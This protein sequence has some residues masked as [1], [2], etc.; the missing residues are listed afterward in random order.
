MVGILCFRYVLD[1]AVETF[2]RSEK[3][4][5]P[6]Y[7]LD[8]CVS[9]VDDVSGG[10]IG[11]Y[12]DMYYVAESLSLDYDAFCEDLTEAL[13]DLGILMQNVTTIVEIIPDQDMY[14]FARKQARLKMKDY[15]WEK[16]S[17]EGKLHS[18]MGE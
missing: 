12:E 1:D 4:G 3:R 15:N 6:Q 5:D 11:Q 7:I 8:V 2:K 18:L 14:S 16:L 10:T 17:T 9:W 13:A